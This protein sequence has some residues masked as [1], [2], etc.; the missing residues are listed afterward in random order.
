VQDVRP[1]QGS[2]AGT[3]TAAIGSDPM[4][5]PARSW[6][7]SAALVVAV[8]VAV[9]LA[10]LLLR[11]ERDL[12]GLVRDPAPSAAGH[13]LLDHRDG[14]PGTPVGLQAPPDGLLLLY[15]GYLSCPDVCPM[16]MADIKR[17]HADL[18]P[19]LADRTLVG[20][21]TLD[22]E[23][24]DGDRLRAYL[25]HFFDDRYLALTAPDP[26]TLDAVTEQLGVRWEVEDHEPG[27]ER[28]D[29]A[30][31]AI[32]YVVDDTGTVVRELPFGT[33]SEDIARVIRALLPPV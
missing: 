32:T 1:P 19:A 10:V 24:D 20:F 27:A 9:A 23:R 29:V 8:A 17:A 7:G 18:G 11:P 22:P 25:T 30:H 16:T 4:S 21:V 13:V 26:A 14:D 12:P 28:Y 31:S 3:T 2:G 6:W 33:T 5:R 15:F